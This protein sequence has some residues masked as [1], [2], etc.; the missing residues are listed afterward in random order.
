MR[1]TFF[2]ACFMTCFL[3]FIG[4]SWAGAAS[5]WMKG[6]GDDKRL[7]EFTILGTHNSCALYGGDYGQCQS[8]GL[9]AQLE[10]GVRF[11]DIRCQWR[12]GD[13]HIVHG[14]A[15][16][17]MKFSEVA[18]ICQDF[19]KEN[20]SETIMMSV[21]EQGGGARKQGDFGKVFHEIIEKS[22]GGW[23]EEKEVPE[24]GDVRGKVVVVSRSREIEGISWSTFFVQDAFWIN[25]EN[26][27]EDKWVKI[28]EHF[29][30][31]Q[32]GEMRK[33]SVNF[34]SCVGVFNPPN[35]TAKKLN[36]KLKVYVEQEE[37]NLGVVVVDFVTEEVFK[38]MC[39]GE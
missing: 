8:L 34:I 37:G 33:P 24:L 25:N 7:S 4:E 27:L 20:A 10:M 2:L 17:K 26:T 21:M 15:D 22:G 35:F 13:L 23:Y 14:V 12:K 38:V 36:E 5:G 6:V 16:Q 1:L 31:I 29:G 28:R 19:L 32:R 18:K 39:L 9:K 11:L 30:V 3:G